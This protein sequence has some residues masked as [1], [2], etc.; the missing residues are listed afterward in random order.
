MMPSLL[1]AVMLV[2][3]IGPAAQSLAQASAQTSVPPATVAAPSI[4][5]TLPRQALPQRGCAA[6][7]WTV[8]DQRLVAMAEHGRLRIMLDDKPV[9]LPVTRAEGAGAFGFAGVTSYAGSGAAVTLSMTVV[10]RD[11][12]K[13]G[14]IVGDAS[15]RVARNG[16]DE[17]AVPVGGLIGCAPQNP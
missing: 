14:A 8:E 2:S 3:A 5:G 4:L 6:F 15:L 11:T 12:L 10:Q 13:D 16:G 7:L 9:D 17:I 1:H